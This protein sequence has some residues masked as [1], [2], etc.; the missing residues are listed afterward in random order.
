[1][2]RWLKHAFAVDPPGPAEPTPRQRAPVDWLC[3]LAARKHMTTPAIVTLEVCRPLNYVGS[4]GLRFL[5]PAAWAVMPGQLF[6]NYTEIA[7][8]LEHRGS[9]EYMIRRV[10]H[11]EA[12][13]KRIES[14]R[15]D[16]GGGA[17]PADAAPPS[18][19]QADEPD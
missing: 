6:R 7:S 2:M 9:I 16:A 5:Q 14:A 8:F 19:R 15:D 10:E 17:T 18:S 11:W 12:E 13:L 1:M 4:M 3:R